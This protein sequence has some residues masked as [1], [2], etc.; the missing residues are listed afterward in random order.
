MRIE[1]TGETSV[2]A[3]VKYG[4]PWPGYIL[5][6]GPGETWELAVENAHPATHPVTFEAEEGNPSGTVEVWSITQ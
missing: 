1:N 3:H 5:T 4:F 2:D 6:V